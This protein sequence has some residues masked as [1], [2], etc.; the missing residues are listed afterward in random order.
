M[1][2]VKGLGADLEMTT[3]LHVGGGGST[4]KVHIVIAL[5]YTP[6]TGAQIKLRRVLGSIR[7]SDPGNIYRV[8]KD[9]WEL[10]D[11]RLLFE[12]GYVRSVSIFPGCWNSL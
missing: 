1:D 10:G 2:L 9:F 8:A 11:T 7:M 3:E 6:S 5:L 12:A 4:G